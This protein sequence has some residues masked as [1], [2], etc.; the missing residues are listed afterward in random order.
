MTLI[1]FPP[2]LLRNT[3]LPVR[4][5]LFLH[6]NAHPDDRSHGKMH[7]QEVLLTQVQ[8]L[9]YLRQMHAL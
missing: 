7:G 3:Y 9:S 1:T 6:T 8:F 2:S 5:L 4:L